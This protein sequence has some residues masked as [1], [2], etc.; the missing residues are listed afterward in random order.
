MG[1]DE[2]DDVGESIIF[3]FLMLNLSKSSSSVFVKCDLY[4]ASSAISLAF[5]N[6]SIINYT[7][8]NNK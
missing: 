4:L 5:V 1:I 3:L 7:I 2:V 6:D 8:I